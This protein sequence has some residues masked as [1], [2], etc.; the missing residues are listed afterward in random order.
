VFIGG[1]PGTGKTTLA[2]A[3]APALDAVVLD[4]D[5]VTGPLTDLLLRL[6]GAADLSEPAFAELTRQPRYRTLLSV[7]AQVARAG[8]SCVV[9]APFG[10]E[11]DAA[12]W[13]EAVAPLRPFADPALVWLTL[14]PDELARRLAARAAARDAVKLR[15]PAGFAARLDLSAPTAP[16]LRLDAARASSELAGEVLRH[17]H[18]LA[19]DG[20][21]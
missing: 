21:P 14:A 11:R 6:T 2:E 10:A 5:V 7:A 13:A 3:L 18:R 8:T 1:P 16:H 19:I 9:V 4:L 20:T 12:R 15:D 17:L